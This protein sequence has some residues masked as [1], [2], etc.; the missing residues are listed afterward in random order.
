MEGPLAPPTPEIPNTDG[1]FDAVLA[2]ELLTFAYPPAG[3]ISWIGGSF[4]GGTLM[5]L[6]M[7]TLQWMS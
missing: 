4:V 1:K 2:K 7:Y 3:G 5:R 6:V